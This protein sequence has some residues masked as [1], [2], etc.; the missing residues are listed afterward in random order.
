ADD[1]TDGHD[2]ICFGID[3]AGFMHLS[4]GMH[5]AALNYAVSTNPVAGNLPIGFGPII[6]M[7]GQENSVTYPQFFNAPN[8]DLF[9]FFREVDSGGGDNYLNRYILATHSWTNVNAASGTQQPF[10]K[11][12]GWVPDYNAYLN[13]PCI[14]AAGNLYLVWTWRGTPAYQ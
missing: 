7:T 2:V 10:I 5:N 6:P 8:G 12:L 9:Y 4:W 13:M 14:D 3:G 1:I 11:G